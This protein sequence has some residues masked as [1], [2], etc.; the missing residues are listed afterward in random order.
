MTEP[1]TRPARAMIH[2]NPDLPSEYATAA[3]RENLERLGEVVGEP[4]VVEAAPEE[5]GNRHGVPAGYVRLVFEALV[6]P[7][8]SEPRH[9]DEGA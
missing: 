7:H 6:I 9:A 1:R 2:V 3:A 5:A 8:G 4:I